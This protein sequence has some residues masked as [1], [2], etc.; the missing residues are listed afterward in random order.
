[1]YQAV[2]PLSLRM[3]NMAGKSLRLLGIPGAS[4][5]PARLMRRAR[6]ATNLSDF[7]PDYFR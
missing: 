7:G 1:M 2:L 5:K 4:L 6:Q 3:L